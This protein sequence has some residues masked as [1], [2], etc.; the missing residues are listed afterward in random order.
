MKK[1]TGLSNLPRA[2]KRIISHWIGNNSMTACHNTVPY[3]GAQV[4]SEKSHSNIRSSLVRVTV[5][6]T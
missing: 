5:V 2:K 6:P 3:S 4:V 1:Q